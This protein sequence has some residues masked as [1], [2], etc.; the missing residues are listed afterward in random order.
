MEYSGPTS[1][2]IDGDWVDA[3]SDATIET[4]DPAT[5]EPY[6]TVARAGESDVDAAVE[7][8]SKA[9]ERGSEW[10]TMGPSERG[11]LLHAM[12]DA[13][14]ERKDEITL[15]E[16]HDNGKTPFEAGMEVQMV[17][18]TFRYYAG[19]TD[20]VTGDYN[21]VPGKRVNYTTR[22]PLGV[23]GH[24]VPWNYPFQLAG[25]S[26]A[27]ALACGNTAV[28]K[29]SSQ[30]PLSALYYGLAAEEAGLPDGVVNIV[31]GS[32]SEAGSALASHSDVEHVT[33]TGSTE[34][35]KRVM[36]DAAENVTGVTLELGGKG[37][38][39]VFPDADL[40]AAAK[41]VHYGIFMNAGQMC[42]A[43]S[44]LLVHEDVADEL[45][46]KIVQRAEST[47]LGSG[48]DDDGRMGPVVSE[49]HQA[50]VLEYISIGADEGATVACGGGRP[51][52][53]EDGYFVEPTVL[54]DVTNDMTVARE[55]IFGPV[56]SVI[57][58]EDQAEAIE[59]A[60]DSPYGLLA[61]IWTDGLSRAHQ[62]AD[63]L[64]YGMVSVNEYPVT[65]PQ[66]PFGG[67]KQSG[68]GREQGEEAVREFTQ[69]KNINLNI[70]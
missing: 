16:S 54:T 22:E 21:P 64:D 15:V 23:T 5:E 25:R 8:A 28:L 14:E 63:A 57:E 61:G 27:P 55:E 46:E 38:N 52:D 70:H 29:P 4:L 3:A 34:I 26:L 19:W 18:D 43:G 1:L 35:G 45:V 41:G 36:A 31:P 20:K 32:G 6:A 44:R 12:A 37:P 9:A 39:V 62:V 7:A 2:Y 10:R 51:E 65:F 49:S 53:K 56:L 58:F 47:P 11:E 48:I 17:I 50:D 67:T 13:I 69:A 68:H 60:N 30:T 42:W 24:I 40:D 59:I 33:F 66:T